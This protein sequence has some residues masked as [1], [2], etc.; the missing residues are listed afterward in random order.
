[1]RFGGRLWLLACAA[2]LLVLLLAGSILWR[3]DI[4]RTLL[5]PKVPF[6]TYKPPPAADYA[7]T[8]AWALAP[9][10]ARAWSTTDPSADVFFIHPTTYDGGRNWNGAIDDAKADRVLSRTMLPNYAGPFARVG[11][12]FA[13]RYRQASLYAML[14]L[15][16]DAREARRFAYED[17]RAAW[18]SY[19]D[20]S[21][22]GRPFIVAGVEQGGGLAARLVAEEIAP[23]TEL[24]QRLAA[25][26]LIETAVSAAN[27]AAGATVPACARPEQ[28]ACVVAY[29]M[30][31]ELDGAR[32]AAIRKRSIAFDAQGQLTSVD[33]EGVLCVNPLTGKA[34][35][36]RASQRLN[37]GAANATGLEWGSRPPF[38]QRQVWAQCEGGVLTVGR[39]RS[40]SLHATGSWADRQRVP[41]Y[42]LFYADL[43]SDAKARVAALLARPGFKMP[44]APIGGVITVRRV[45]I[46]RID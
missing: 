39:P 23:Y 5:D 35:Q 11:R 43:E 36:T 22:L 9:R 19:L 8:T 21:N 25:V 10:N 15:R 40:P 34:D 7:D 16:D 3:D 28:A 33:G 4:L 29:A 46:Y 44:P 38:L 2:G 14:T 13:P 18:R 31:L 17:V 20:R 24:V 37:K 42:N 32:A 6:Q 30:A 26:Y 45:P 27:Y 12:I 41:D 1:M